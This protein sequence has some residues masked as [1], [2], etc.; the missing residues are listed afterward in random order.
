VGLDEPL[1]VIDGL[2]RLA[3]LRGALEQEQRLERIDGKL[4]LLQEMADGPPLAS[5]PGWDKIRVSVPLGA[6]APPPDREAEEW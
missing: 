5:I 6:I 1:A 4:A 2:R 3:A